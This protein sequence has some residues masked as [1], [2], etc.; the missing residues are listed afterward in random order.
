M[1]IYL[2]GPVTHEPDNGAKWREAVKA[3]W[4][5][6]HLPFTFVDPV[7]RLDKSV[8][9]VDPHYLVSHD[10]QLL[11]GCDALLVGLTR[12]RSIGT[13]R[14]AEYAKD[15]LGIPVAVW[16]EPT[17]SKGDYEVDDLDH[18][19]LELGEC[20]PSFLEC[21]TYLLDEVVE[22]EPRDWKFP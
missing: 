8:E 21:L 1:R 18:W 13:W 20:S 2:A 22:E 6:E 16:L 4:Q 17:G 3:K 5:K 11:D 12:R 14:E 19:I 15:N 10:K 9:D 7:E